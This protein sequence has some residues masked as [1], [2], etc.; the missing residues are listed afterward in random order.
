LLLCQ[1]LKRQFSYVDQKARDEYKESLKAG[2]GLINPGHFIKSIT[3][4]KHTAA[5]PSIT[6][7]VLER[8]NSLCALEPGTQIVSSAR[9]QRAS[10]RPE[11]FALASAATHN[12]FFHQ[13]SAGTR[14]GRSFASNNRPLAMAALHFWAR[15]L[16]GAW[17]TIK[18]LC[19]YIRTAWPD[20]YFCKCDSAI[21]SYIY[22]CERASAPTIGNHI[23]PRSQSTL[24]EGSIRHQTR[25]EKRN[26]HRP[27]S[28]AAAAALFDPSAQC[29]S[30]HFDQLTVF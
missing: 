10:P 12:G 14:A 3:P 20:L 30:S 24:P 18:P 8:N 6:I 15:S 17:V 23:T 16:L 28:V 27:R 7:M 25:P 11:K 19:K 26:R 13:S 29:T 2:D 1:N 9:A 22:I 5:G 4:L 21:H